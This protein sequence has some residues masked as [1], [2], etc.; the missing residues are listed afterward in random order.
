MSNIA[1]LRDD[2]TII[3]IVQNS[4]II[5]R[6]VVVKLL[7]LEPKNIIFIPLYILILIYTL[8]HKAK[9]CMWHS[10]HYSYIIVYLN[11]L[12]VTALSKPLTLFLL[13]FT[14]TQFLCFLTW[15][16][17]LSSYA[18]GSSVGPACRRSPSKFQRRHL[19][20]S[21]PPRWD[22]PVSKYQGLMNGLNS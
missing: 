14:I 20:G 7:T 3:A 1:T 5:P 10:L 11:D 21:S 17:C 4:G 13:F 16:Q 8:H 12:V 2:Y 18:G 9:N 22:L 15:P 6:P 19:S